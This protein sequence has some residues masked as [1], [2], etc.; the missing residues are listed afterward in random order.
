MKPLPGIR[1]FYCFPRITSNGSKVTRE[2]YK[3]AESPEPNSLNTPLQTGLSS[4]IRRTTILS[5]NTFDGIIPR[6]DLIENFLRS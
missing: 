2:P 6:Y 4:I 5:T 3:Q 1:G